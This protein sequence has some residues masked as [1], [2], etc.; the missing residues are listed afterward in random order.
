MLILQGL[1]LRAEHS[2]LLVTIDAIVPIENVSSC[3]SCHLYL[4]TTPPK[5]KIFTENAAEGQECKTGHVKGR[6]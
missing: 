3:T 4:T 1:T 5:L 2:V 6:T